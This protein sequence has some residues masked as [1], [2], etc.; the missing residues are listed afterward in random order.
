MGE[1]GGIKKNMSQLDSAEGINR[2]EQSWM[3]LIG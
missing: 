2:F 1:Q 3:D